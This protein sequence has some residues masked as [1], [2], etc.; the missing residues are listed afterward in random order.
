M[1]RAS[2]P[3]PRSRLLSSVFDERSEFEFEPDRFEA[4]YAELEAALYEGRCVTTVIAPLL[5]L[6]LDPGSRELA[7]GDGLSLV[8][9]DALPDAPTEA[10]WGDGEEPNV[11]VVLTVTQERTARPGGVDRA[12]PLPARP[13]RAAAV[14]ARRLRARADRLDPHRRGPVASL[15]ARRRGRARLLTLVSADAGG[16]AAGVLQP[17]LPPHADT[18]ASWP[19][20]FRASRWGAS[21]SRRSRR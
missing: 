15:A 14:R 20:R 18:G 10:V 12:R 21:G 9:G 3:T 19:G 4:A 13:H 8:R 16:R 7:L 17:D 6:A 11:L 1:S 2:A 5:G